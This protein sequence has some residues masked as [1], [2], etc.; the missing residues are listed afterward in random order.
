MRKKSEIK[1]LTRNREYRTPKTLSWERT[2]ELYGDKRISIGAGKV[3][4]FVDLGR[5]K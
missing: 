4:D 5:D 3:K 2:A 1:K